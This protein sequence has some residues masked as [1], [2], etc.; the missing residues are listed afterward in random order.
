MLGG[1]GSLLGNCEEHQGALESFGQHLWVWGGSGSTR[2]PILTS[3]TS[4]LTQGIEQ[5]TFSMGGDFPFGVDI[6]Q[7]CS[8]LP[9]ELF[10]MH[11]H[12]DAITQ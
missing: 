10:L 12:P 8:A 6:P 4:H 9:W 3:L 1:N 7:C 5:S 11:P 2:R